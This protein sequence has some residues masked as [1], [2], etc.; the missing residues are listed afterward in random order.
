VLFALAWRWTMT[1]GM[2]AEISSLWLRPEEFA[3]GNASAA[4]TDRADYPAAL[5]AGVDRW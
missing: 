3:T 1:L 4:R 5:G 2:F